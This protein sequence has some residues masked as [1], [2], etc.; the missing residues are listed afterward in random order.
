MI[1]NPGNITRSKLVEFGYSPLED[2]G[3]LKSFASGKLPYGLRTNLSPGAQ[4][5]QEENG[6]WR[7]TIPSGQ[8][9]HY[10]LAQLDDYGTLARRAFRWQPPLNLTLRARASSKAISGTWGFGLWNDPFGMG[11]LNGGE[12]LRLPTLPNAAWYFFASPQN[13]LSLR[14][15]LPAQGE[16][17][18]TFR[19]PRWPAALSI[20]AAPALPFL[21]LPSM[22]RIF[23]RMASRLVKQD[24]YSLPLDPT[25]WH[26][27]RLVWR[28]EYTWF[29]VDGETQLQTTISPHGALGLVLWVDNQFISIPPDGRIKYGMLPTEEPTWIEIGDLSIE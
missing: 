18:A 26:R 13:Y 7:L 14:N 10:R 29:E 6:V 20:L 19:S 28:S 12:L 17:C 2:M 3:N 4:V 23:R 9:G 21:A 16:L 11:I 1:S 15:D 25:E 22:L 24:A 5:E 8:A 27:Y